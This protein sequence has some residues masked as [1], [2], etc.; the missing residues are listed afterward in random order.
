MRKDFEGNHCCSQYQFNHFP[1]LLHFFFPFF[2]FISSSFLSELFYSLLK[3]TPSSHIKQMQSLGSFRAPFLRF[4]AEKNSAQ[5]A[6]ILNEVGRKMRVLETFLVE[7]RKTYPRPALKSA[8]ERESKFRERERERERGRGRNLKRK[9]L[10]AR[11]EQ[12]KN[13]N[14]TMTFGSRERKREDS[15]TSECLN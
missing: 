2:S 9:S 1:L 10:T 4:G 5:S 14:N 15:A 8:L 3:S 7:S 11:E 12:I 13:L 6:N